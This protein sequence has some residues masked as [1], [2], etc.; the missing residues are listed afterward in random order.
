MSGGTRFL[1]GRSI[2]GS[3]DYD[4]QCD[5][6]PAE[7]SCPWS[8]AHHSDL[9][10][11]LGAGAPILDLRVRKPLETTG[12]GA[13]STPYACAAARAKTGGIDAAAKHPHTALDFECVRTVRGAYELCNFS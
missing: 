7:P 5:R 1:R 3:A 10:F 13:R 9:P 12:C 4:Q 11:S 6:D 2:E 8:K